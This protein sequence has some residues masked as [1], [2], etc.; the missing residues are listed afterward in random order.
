MIRNVYRS[1]CEIPRRLEQSILL[2][3]IKIAQHGTP[4]HGRAL[5]ERL[6]VL[7]LRSQLLN[8]LFELVVR[9]PKIGVRFLQVAMLGFEGFEFLLEML[10][11]FLLALA[12]G[13]LGGSIL[14]S[15]SLEFPI[16]QLGPFSSF[17]WMLLEDATRENTYYSHV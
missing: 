16:R 8:L 12:E 7:D 4:Q 1:E 5:A 10:D 13:A 2:E 9:F 11:V 14:R 17:V 3:L 15:A 6:K